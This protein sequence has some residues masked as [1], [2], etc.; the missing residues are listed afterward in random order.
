MITRSI[1]SLSQVRQK[2]KTNIGANRQAQRTV[3]S[4]SAG[5]MTNE[6]NAQPMGGVSGEKM[7]QCRR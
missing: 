5:I 6:K 2:A 7:K 3:V 1:M 4:K